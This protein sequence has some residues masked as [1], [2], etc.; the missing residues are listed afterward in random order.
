MDLL[1]D[2][3]RI[4]MGV[5]CVIREFVEKDLTDGIFIEI[6]LNKP[7]APRK[8]GLATGRN[9]YNENSLNKFLEQ[10]MHNQI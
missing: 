8:I 10:H 7:V 1:I 6:P 4:S 9:T 5:A 2:F 3:A